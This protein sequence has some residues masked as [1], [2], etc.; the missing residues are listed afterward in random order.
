MGGFFSAPKPP[1]L[2]PPPP[3]PDPAE[4]E[5]QRRLETIERRRRGRAGLIATSARGLLE[6]ALGPAVRKSLLGE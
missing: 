4:E 5:R 6:G 1:P 2:P 3:P